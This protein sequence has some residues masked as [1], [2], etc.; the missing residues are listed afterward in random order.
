MGDGGLAVSESVA[1]IAKRRSLAFVSEI[2]P[3]ELAVRLVEAE[4]GM[5]RPS[6]MTPKQVLDG[7]TE[8]FRNTALHMARVAAE[9]I[10]ECINAGRAPS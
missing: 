9:Y 1:A 4:M 8:E 10:A 7:Q 5:K 6:H 3:Y 2:D